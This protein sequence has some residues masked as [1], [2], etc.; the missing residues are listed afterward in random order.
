MM[1]TCVPPRQLRDREQRDT[2]RRSVGKA[3]APAMT[4]EVSI[5]CPAPAAGLRP[6][7]RIGDLPTMTE[8]PPW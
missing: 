7:F 3:L 5:A 8:R 2:S 6:E 4:F 1:M